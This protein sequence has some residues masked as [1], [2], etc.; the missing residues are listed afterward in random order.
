M[1]TTTKSAS[2]SCSASSRRP[3]RVGWKR[4]RSCRGPE[5]TS[6][7]SSSGP[8]GTQRSGRLSSTISKT[9]CALPGSSH[10][11]SSSSTC[12]DASSRDGRAGSDGLSR[13]ERP[14]QL[15]RRARGARAIAVGGTAAAVTAA[16][17]ASLVTMVA[18]GSSGWD[19]GPGIASQ[20]QG[21]AG[22][23]YGARRRGR[24]GVRAG[25]RDDARSIR[26]AR[27]ARL[28]A[29]AGPAARGR[30][31]AADRRGCGRRRRA[32][33]GRRGRGSPHLKPDATAAAALA[34]AATQAATH[35]VEINLAIV[36]GDRHSE[37]AAR[38]R[39]QRRQRGRARWERR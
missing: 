18:R 20:S 33:C 32:R 34:E 29:R 5:P 9:H 7:R 38:S 26:H 4:H 28:R 12:A 13:P 22:A 23:A 1:T 14:R 15:S 19:D 6:T 16:M 39:P 3:L 17:A 11:P 36:P 24:D 8:S 27:A 10:A 37:R 2:A 31:T 35:L 25:P 30:G 21:V